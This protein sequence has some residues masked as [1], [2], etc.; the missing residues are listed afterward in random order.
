MAFDLDDEELEMTR[1]MHNL[2]SIKKVQEDVIKGETS[3]KFQ[4]MS[5]GDDSEMSRGQ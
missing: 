5:R 4:D 3:D 2:K 1:K